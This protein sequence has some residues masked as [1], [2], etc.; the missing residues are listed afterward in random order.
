MMLLFTGLLAAAAAAAPVNLENPR[1]LHAAL[2]AEKAQRLESARANFGATA[3]SLD[4]LNYDATYY[5]LDVNLIIATSTIEGR[6]QMD[7]ISL[8]DNL[9][10]FDVD[11]HL[12]L[13]ADS[14]FMGGAPVPFSHV[15][16]ELFITPPAPLDS[17]DAF[18]VI[19]YY[20]GIPPGGGFGAFGFST[21]GVPSVPMIWSLSEPYYSRNWWP[22]KDTPSDK[23]DSAD[24]H[25]TCRDD[26]FATSNG[27]L[28]GETD[29]GDGTKTYDWHHGYPITTYLISVAATNYV[30]LDYWYTYNGGADSMPVNFWVYPESQA[31]ALTSYPE[32]V[33][34]I[35]AL[36]ESY[37]PYPFLD[38]KYAISQFVWGGGMEHQTN[39]SQSSTWYSWSLNS[40]ELAHQW[41]GDMVTCKTWS[42]IW[43]NEGFASYSEALYQ[44][45]KSG[46]SAYQS[47]MNGMIYTGG[48][49][50]YVYDTSNVGMIFHGG[51][52]YDKG[53]WVVHMLRHVLGDATFFDAL[54]EYRNQYLYKSATTDD[55]RVVCE[56]VSGLDLSQFFSDWIFGTYYPRYT[57]AFYTVPDGDSVGVKVKIDQL[58]LSPP[59]VFNMPID[60][61]FTDGVET[62]TLVVNN[63]E[64]SQWFDLKLSFEPT[65]MVLDPDGWILQFS[66]P[67]VAIVTDSLE[68][69][70]RDVPYID[71]LEA[72]RGHAPYSW[73]LAIGSALPPG[74]SLSS[75][76]VIQGTPSVEN[77][78]TFTVRVEDS[79]V[80]GA[81]QTNMER[82][83]TLVVGPPLRPAGDI[84]ADGVVTST[85]IISLVAYVFKGGTAPDPVSFGD[86]DLSCTVTS[87]DIIYLVNYVFK[88]GP[89]PHDGCA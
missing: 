25:I 63:D 30:R 77:S 7:A 2:A 73:E 12:S 11:L 66:W 27:T 23:A 79:L 33:Q 65:S 32:I 22:C 81:P 6:V 68:P 75:S 83:I 72:V 36:S 19:M 76:G 21:H 55:F 71:T 61:R 9:T 47:W 44:E 18:S 5:D 1:E 50:I 39:T 88:A 3:A 15:G 56:Q 78:F 20:H 34:M 54:A 52:S 87:A 14:V 45:W 48:G 51:R 31:S 43:L 29:N 41:W 38:E 28:V 57:Y 16:S 24:I 53:A 26:L 85:D 59:Q 40:H 86:V 82:E 37:G 4:Q 8:I 17:G 35:G 62:R 64:R 42:D 70:R 74:L 49:T 84:N 67:G 89:K 58:Q 10:Q 13:V 60:L 80:A 46:V 69:A